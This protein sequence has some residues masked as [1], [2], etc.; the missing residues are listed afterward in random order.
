MGECK[1]SQTIR[2]GHIE[3]DAAGDKKLP[4]FALSKHDLLGRNLQALAEQSPQDRPG[5]DELAPRRVRKTARPPQLL[6]IEN[7]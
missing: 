7:A 1:D 6:G 2:V 4:V 3:Q 5:G